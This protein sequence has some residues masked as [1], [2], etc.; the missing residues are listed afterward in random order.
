VKLRV[1]SIIFAK[2]DDDT[3]DI[4]ETLAVETIAAKA[5]MDTKYV[6]VTASSTSGRLR[7]LTGTS[8]A[9][10]TLNAKVGAPGGWSQK[11]LDSTVESSIL[12]EDLRLEMQEMMV[13]LDGL[14]EASSGEMAFEEIEAQRDEPEGTTTLSP[15]VSDS[16]TQLPKAQSTSFRGGDVVN[17]AGDELSS[18]NTY[19]FLPVLIVLTSLIIECP[20]F[21]FGVVAV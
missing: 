6:S 7:R 19:S 15:P 13:E 4:V 17:L 18:A 12:S 8:E 16:S 11:K 3:K 21:D 14:Q 2:V 1:T 9:G 10:M 20:W 5:G